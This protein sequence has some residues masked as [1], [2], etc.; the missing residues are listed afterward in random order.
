MALKY[1]PKQGDICYINFLP[2]LESEE[3]GLRPAIIISND[4]YIELTKMVIVCPIGSNFKEFPTHYPLF[5]TKKVKGFVLCEHLRSID[6][7]EENLSFV[8]KIENEELLKIIDL[9]YSFIEV[10]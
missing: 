8:E 4:D 6:Y 9:V 5:N 1:K 3:R 7:S 2:T 10:I